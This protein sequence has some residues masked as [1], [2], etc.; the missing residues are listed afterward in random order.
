MYLYLT[1]ILIYKNL[2]KYSTVKRVGLLE[3]RYIRRFD[4]YFY[5]LS[6]IFIWEKLKCEFK[7]IFSSKLWYKITPIIRF[8]FIR[9][10]NKS[11]CCCICNGYSKNEILVK[12][13]CKH[14][15]KFDILAI[16]KKFEI[17][18]TCYIEV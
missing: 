15:E 18:I 3:Y 4:H 5:N 7:F 14:I 2:M 13:G 17:E 9:S 1:E 10:L 16:S 11:L 6:I 8:Y 12:R